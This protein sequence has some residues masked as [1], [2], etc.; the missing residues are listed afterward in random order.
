MDKFT[1]TVMKDGMVYLRIWAYDAHHFSVRF[2]EFDDIRFYNTSIT[3]EFD[4]EQL[5]M[6]LLALDP[7]ECLR[8]LKRLY[9]AAQVPYVAFEHRYRHN[10]LLGKV[11]EE[12]IG[13]KDHADCIP[14]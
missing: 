1:H 7:K 8:F 9:D 13:E 6:F 12:V 3:T 14:L 5:V 10:P 11:W 2:P 4:Q